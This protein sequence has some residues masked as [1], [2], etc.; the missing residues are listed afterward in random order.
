MTFGSA[1]W[2]STPARGGLARCRTGS[3]R[4]SVISWPTPSTPSG[5]VRQH[6]RQARGDPLLAHGNR[7]VER[8]GHHRR[9]HRLEGALAEAAVGAMKF[10]AALLSSPVSGPSR[11]QICPWPCLPPTNGE[12]RRS[13]SG[14]RQPDRPTPGRPPP[15]NTRY[16]L[17]PQVYFGTVRHQPAATRGPRRCRRR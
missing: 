6:A 15:A 1:V 8:S 3:S 14:Q 11:S 7:C 17:A 2:S 13:D 10:A 4:P 16:A 9:R 5:Q 12:R